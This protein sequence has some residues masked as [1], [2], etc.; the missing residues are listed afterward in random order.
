[1]LL[2]VLLRAG[3]VL[4]LTVGAYWL[5]RRLLAR[6]ALPLLRRRRPTWALPVEHSRLP[7]LTALLMAVVVLGFA[8]VLLA[9]DCATVKSHYVC[10]RSS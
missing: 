8:V 5:T 3:L 1:M 6:F 2:D 9:D 7:M 4:V 10:K